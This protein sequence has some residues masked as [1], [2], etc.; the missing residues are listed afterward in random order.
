[1]SESLVAILEPAL[2][3][4]LN[5]LALGLAGLIFKAFEWLGVKIDDSARQRILGGAE[6]AAELGADAILKGATKEAGI[7]IATDYITS[8]F[9]QSMKRLKVTP[10]EIGKTVEAEIIKK[11]DA[12][13]PDER[14]K[15]LEQRIESMKPVKLS[16]F[17]KG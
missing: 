2:L 7:A 17:N 3:V 15:E 6:R 14:V 12:V 4:V 9:E 1:M 11:L 13:K 8:R 5:A 16:G 10:E